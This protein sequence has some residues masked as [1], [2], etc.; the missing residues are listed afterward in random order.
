MRLVTFSPSI[1]QVTEFHAKAARKPHPGHDILVYSK[2]Q[3][4]V[5]SDPSHPDSL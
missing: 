5:Y 4:R 2:V 1:G 3:L